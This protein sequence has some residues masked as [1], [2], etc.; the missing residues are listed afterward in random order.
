M[1]ILLDECVDE[2]FRHEFLGHDCRT[3]RFAKLTGLKN[4]QLLTAAEAQKFDVLITVGQAMPYQQNMASRHIAVMVLCVPT[5]R[6]QE[7]RK[8]APL[9]LD[10]LTAIRPGQMIRL[11]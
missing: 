2:R 1:R 4:G 10:S 9:T 8:L 11:P 7:L 5:N 6:I 3:A